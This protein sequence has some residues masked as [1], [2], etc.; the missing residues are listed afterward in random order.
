LHVRSVLT[1]IDKA[2]K[3]PGG[4]GVRSAYDLLCEVAHPNA[5]GYMRYLSHVEAVDE[6]G[7]ELRV[8]APDPVGNTCDPIIESSLW[9]ISWGASAVLSAFTMAR[10]ALA[11]I[12]KHTWGANG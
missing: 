5:L 8:I 12:E 6:H 1:A 4:S 10:T 11:R 7:E 9:G 2:G 3:M